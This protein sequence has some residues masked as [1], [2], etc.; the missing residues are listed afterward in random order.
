L[1]ATGALPIWLTI[2]QKG[3]RLSDIEFL[4]I[5]EFGNKARS[6]E[7]S[8]SAVGDIVSLTATAGKDMYLARAKVIVSVN[9]SSA[10]VHSAAIELKANGVIKETAR[11]VVR[12]TSNTTGGSTSSVV[13]EFGWIGKVA[14]GQIIK[15]E[16]ITETG[17]V[18]V[19]GFLEVFEEDTGTTPQV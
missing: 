6:N 1:S 19:D 3:G 12:S 7:G 17:E 14:A 4:A 18:N 15:L 10:G 8:V 2:L 11:P 5:K 9:V 16:F 13:Y